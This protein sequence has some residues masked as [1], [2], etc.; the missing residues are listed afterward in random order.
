[1]NRTRPAVFLDRDGTINVEVNYLRRLEEIQLLPGVGHAMEH[2]RAAGYP[3][4]VITNQSAVARGMITEADLA[5]I[6][7]E[8]Q[9]QLHDAGTE[10]D[11]IYYCPHHPEHG[12]PPYRRDC[13]CRKPNP[14]LLKRAALDLGL[15]LERSYMVGDNLS[16]LQSGWNAGCRVVLVRTGYG[17][18]T[19]READGETR[20]RIDCIADD[21]SEA[22]DW[23]VQQHK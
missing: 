14:G 2:L 5:D 12:S 19:C 18:G 23:I 10:V 15:D 4:V 22:A 1:M 21:L 13:A 11:G 7:R 3:L 8:L 6:H 20:D 17:A 16:D 9:R